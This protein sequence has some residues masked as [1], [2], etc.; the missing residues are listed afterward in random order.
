[1]HILAHYN[2]CGLT[3]LY[4]Q[5]L[6]CIGDHLSPLRTKDPVC[7]TTYLSNA[8]SLASL[9]KSP[10]PRLKMYSVQETMVA[11]TAY[12]CSDSLGAGESGVQTPRGARFSIPIQTGPEA[13][14]AL[15]LGLF[16]GGVLGSQGM[17]MTTHNNQVQRLKK[18]WSYTSMPPLCLHGMLYSELYLFA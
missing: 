3:L 5:L 14:S 12:L 11:R 18:G 17:A 2:L 6:T 13:H 4:A 10:P 16:L 7:P 9:P 1:M 15:V 8:D